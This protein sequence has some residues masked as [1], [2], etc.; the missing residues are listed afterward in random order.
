MKHY[1]VKTDVFEGPLDLLLH[2]INKLE[3]DIYDIPMAEITEQYLS[4]IKTMKTIEL[5]V[6]SE[7]L[8]MAATLLH[9]K[10]KMLLPKEKVEI[11]DTYEEDPREELIERLIEYRKYKEAAL[12]L[13]EKETGNEQSFTRPPIMFQQVIEKKEVVQGDLTVYDMIDALENV[14]RRK[15]WIEPMETKIDRFEISIEEAMLN[16]ID[17]LKEKNAS[18]EFNDLFPINHKRYIVTT[19]LALLEL[20]KEQKIN[21][22]QADRFA[23]IYVR[24][25]EGI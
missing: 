20:M 8:V 25:R 10:S 9:I 15:S 16:I 21:I 24:L 18:L 1:E 2:L 19:F 13:K 23:P 7:Y 5:N 3:I 14:L 6:A 12:K 4:F 17:Q 11:D 22:Q